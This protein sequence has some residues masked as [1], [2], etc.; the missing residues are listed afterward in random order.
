MLRLLE[1]STSSRATLTVVVCVNERPLTGCGRRKA[2][3][4]LST[5]KRPLAPLPHQMNERLFTL[6]AARKRPF[7]F[8]SPGLRSS[9][10]LRPG[11]VDPIAKMT[12]RAV[13]AGQQNDLHSCCG[14]GQDLGHQI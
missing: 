12:E 6:I 1:A 13:T 2:A 5:R 11:Q 4:P 7:R 8:P 14:V 10:S 9:F 3:F